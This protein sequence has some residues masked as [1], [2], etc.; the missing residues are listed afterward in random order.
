MSG[1]CVVT[2]THHSLNAEE[3]W[4][5]VEANKVMTVVIVGDSSVIDKNQYLPQQRPAPGEIFAWA[6]RRQP[7]R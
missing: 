2:L 4:T 6:A 7:E 1:G 5:A 3:L